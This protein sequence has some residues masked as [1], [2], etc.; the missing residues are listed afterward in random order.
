MAGLQRRRGRDKSQNRI[1]AGDGAHPSDAD[2]G[3]RVGGRTLR[4]R[5]AGEQHQSGSAEH[6]RQHPVSRREE[7]ARRRSPSEARMK[8]TEPQTRMRP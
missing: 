6:Q 5:Q 2:S 7:R 1:V 4:D 3:C 8:L